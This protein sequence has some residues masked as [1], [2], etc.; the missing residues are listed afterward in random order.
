MDFDL[1]SQRMA[2]L[3][4]PLP[5]IVR[6]DP[7]VPDAATPIHFY[8]GE[9]SIDY[10]QSF[11]GLMD[12]QV[13]CRLLTSRADD[14]SGQATLKKYLSRRGE[15]SVKAALEGTPGVPQTLGGACHDLHVRRMQGHRLYRVGEDTFFG[16]EW[17]V[18]VL[19]DDEEG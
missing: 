7:F 11:G 12:V 6:S 4:E 17:I 9:I 18:R 19:G 15:Y 3:V 1:V 8:V 2:E 16:A 10:D 5:G 14:R 13:G